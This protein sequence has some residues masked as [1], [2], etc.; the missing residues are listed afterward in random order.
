MVRYP[1]ERQ[2]PIPPVKNKEEF[3]A[4]YN[5]MFDEHLK[6]KIIHSDASRN[7]ESVGFHGIAFDNGSVWIGYNFEVN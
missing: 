2:Y 3:V 5:E 7:W 4:R 1:F 6:N